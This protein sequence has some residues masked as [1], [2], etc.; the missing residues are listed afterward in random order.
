MLAD[1]PPCGKPWWLVGPGLP[2]PGGTEGSSRPGTT[3][4]RTHYEPVTRPARVNDI[5]TTGDAELL[6]GRPWRGWG[7]PTLGSIAFELSPS[8][9]LRLLASLPAPSLSTACAVTS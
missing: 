3:L 9:A 4:L 5:E 8:G 2:E 6:S 1:G 7:Q